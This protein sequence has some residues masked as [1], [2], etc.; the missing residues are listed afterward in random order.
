MGSE[1]FEACPPEAYL[2]GENTDLNFLGSKPS[3][4][5][6]SG[7]LSQEPSR[8]LKALMNIRKET[9]RL[10]RIDPST[11]ADKSFP[12]APLECDLEIKEKSSLYNIEFIFDSDVK[13]TIQV[14][15]LC[16]EEMTSSGI[17]YKPRKD[18]HS[19]SPYPYSKGANQLFCQPSYSFDP[20]KY[21]G[22][23]LIYRAFDDQG[24]FD[25]SVPFPV[26]VQCIALEGEEPRQSHVLIAIIEKNHELH[27]TIKPFKQKN[28]INGLVYLMQE[29]YGIENKC[30]REIKRDK[31]SLISPEDEIE[32]NGYECVICMSE[33]RDTMILPCKHLCLCHGCANSLRYQAHNCPICRSPFRA[34]LQLK[35][36]CRSEDVPANLRASQLPPINRTTIPSDPETRSLSAGTNDVPLGYSQIPLIESLNGT[37]PLASG[38]LYNYRVSDSK[39]N[40]LNSSSTKVNVTRS[41]GKDIPRSGSSISFSGC[42]KSCT[43]ESDLERVTI[44]REPSQSVRDI[45]LRV[46]QIKLSS[47]NSCDIECSQYSSSE[48][49]RWDPVK[50]HRKLK[51]YQ[52]DN[53]PSN[54]GACDADLFKCLPNQERRSTINLSHFKM[55]S[56]SDTDHDDENSC[57]NLNQSRRRHSLSK[58]SLGEAEL[59]TSDPRRTTISSSSS[60]SSSASSIDPLISEDML[61]KDGSKDVQRTELVLEE[62]GTAPCRSMASLN[63][64]FSQDS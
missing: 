53:Q 14:H 29:I 46:S 11:V 4:F 9:L 35:A 22:N 63:T 26:V 8:T 60:T 12:E 28:F 36:V 33:T 19:S 50:D 48:R 37:S 10:V 44:D 6:Y 41:L 24:N 23:D 20:S 16:V 39:R 47:F 7:S 54:S 18:A 64:S 56:P 45:P 51:Q 1:R 61:S 59:E 21:S 15:H 31:N 32:D 3:F 49:S 17:I 57:K 38:P 42:K 40:R 62:I 5:P 43:H 58:K 2:F 27:Y 55:H 34:L 30:I 13:C 52:G 25:P